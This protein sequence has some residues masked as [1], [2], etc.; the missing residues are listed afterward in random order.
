MTYVTNSELGF[1]YLRDHL[2]TSAKEV[3]LRPQL[4]FCVVDEGDSVLIDEARVPLIISGKTGAIVDKYDAAAKL[5]AT[6]VP[7]KHYEVF[8][9]EVTISLTEAGTRYA[10]KALQVDNLFDAMNPWASYVSNAIK[11]KELFQKDKA[12]I[13]RDGEVLIV[14]EFS[15]RVMDGRRWGDGL[16][17]SIEAK[18]AL[19]VQS[20][21][22]VVA[23]ITY[24]SL[25]TRFRRLSSMSG[26]AITEAEE[27]A[28]IYNLKVVSVPPVLPKQ[29]IDL[30]NAVYKTVK[31]KSMAALEELLGMHRAGRPVLV[32]TT[33]VEASTAFSEKLKSLEI[34][35]EV[36]NA[37]P[38]ALAREAEIIAQAG[39]RG[40]VTIATNMAGRGTDILLGGSPSAMARL[41]VRAALAAAA[42]VAVPATS[43]DFYP[44]AVSEEAEQRM[45]DAAQ[46]YAAE[47]QE[48]AARL[49]AAGKPPADDVQ[50][51]ADLDEVMA[52]ASSAADVYEDTA[53]DLARE[54]YELVVAT[55]DAALEEEKE[56]VARAGGL[57]V[58]GTNLHDSRR[59]DDQLRGRA[60]RQGDA[61]STH[62]FLS[63]EDR[64]F[65]V[66]GGDK[67][68]KVLDFLRVSE[69]Q[70]LESDQVSETVRSTQ[71]KVERYYFELRKGLFEFDEVLAAQREA[72]YAKRDRTLQADGAAT[73]AMLD[74]WSAAV[75]A[76]IIDANWK[77]ATADE[78]AAELL[79][80]KLQQFFPGLGLT[81]PELVGVARDAAQAS[82]T[83]AV[84]AAVQAKTQ[85]LE[86]VREGLAV[87]AARFL[88]LVQTDNLWKGHMKAMNYVKDFAGLK[89]YAQE[90]P[91]QV[92]REEGLTL[93]ATMEKSLRQN[94][95]FSYMAYQPK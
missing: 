37:K 10:E 92:Y 66:F 24:Q 83:A 86:A 63:L 71:D 85:T 52:V 46:A 8:E 12:Y 56:E 47:A 44:C 20:E 4:N 21:T 59:I 30:P 61:G 15:G 23:Q 67:V 38:E 76:D 77:G 26:T 82:A 73:T 88:A 50:R 78:A 72:T 49:A 74:E 75:V 17:Q 29:R 64:I 41:R 51:L 27:M 28:T 93:F 33:S 70:A 55:F 6:L 2:A 14:D 19:E 68:V 90:H 69:D 57:H 62:F 60:G 1:D 34:P 31:G 13:V 18:E 42:G 22:E 7:G 54:A 16:H 45:R 94:T 32:G 11:A 95:V 9:K 25:F 58:I 43:A 79:L 48:A 3:V 65:R 39:R 89:V 5:A 36:L 53:S 35:H 84:H 80:G 87:E 40:A 81:A 91:L